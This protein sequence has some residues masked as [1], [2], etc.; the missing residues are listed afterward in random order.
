MS[1]ILIKNGVVATL[2]KE[3]NIIEKGAV[4]IE[5]NKIKAVGNSSDIEKKYKADKV[6]DAAGKLVMPGLVNSHMHFYSTFA[7]GIDIK[8]EAPYTFMEIL[9]RLWWKLD[10]TLTLDGVYYS[11][12]FPMIEAIKKGTT[13]LIDHHASPMA[14]KGSLFKIS[15]AVKKTGLRAAL[16][17]EVSD[18]DGEKI[19]DQGI[20]ENVDFIKA[21]DGEMLA[22]LFGL[23]AAFTVSDE[24]LEKEK[25]ALGDI[26]A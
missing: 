23:H 14:V 20:E 19:A 10:K 3:K 7:Q 12:L 5:D 6:I 9:E 16:C 17:Y 13:T 8:A 1:S 25:K 2:S 15:D 26:D 18:R 21:A 11:A 24:T 4:Y 22:G